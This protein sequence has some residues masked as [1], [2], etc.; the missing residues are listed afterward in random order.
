MKRKPR[1]HLF[2]VYIF[3]VFMTMLSII[4]FYYMIIAGTYVTEEIFTGIKLLPGKAF[5]DNFKT[6]MGTN[7]ALFYRNSLVVALSST[8]G[9]VFVSSL[10]GFAFAKMEFPGKKFLFMFILG[11]IMIPGQMGLVGLAMEMRAFH[12]SNT[13][14][15][16][17]FPGLANAFGVFWMKQYMESS[18][19]NEIIESANMDGCNMATTFFRIA[20]PITRP[21]LITMFLLFFLWSWNDYLTP[22]VMIN[23]QDRYTIPLAITILGSLHRTDYAARILAL[24]IATIPILIIF[25]CGSKYLIQGMV[26]GSI[27]G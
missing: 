27:K 10:T 26:A 11:T 18:V 22:L 20:L 4:P 5:L 12:F 16:L 14:L 25:T 9:V 1:I 23:N 6:V 13:H 7:F 3:I 8:I 2:F 21:A 15:A 19:P 17:I 24:S